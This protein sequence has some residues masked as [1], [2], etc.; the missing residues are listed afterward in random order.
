MKPKH[1]LKPTFG[2]RVMKLV[3]LLLGLLLGGMVAVTAY[4]Q[5]QI[6]Q[7][8]IQPQE[9]LPTLQKYVAE[10]LSYGETERNGDLIGGKGSGIVN[11]LLIGQD[12]EEG[13]ERA[14]SDS[15]ILCSFN[16]KSKKLTMTSFLRDLYVKIPG[17]GSNRI[18]AAYTFG[19]MEL[20]DRTIRENFGVYIDAN[21][22]VDFTQFAQIVNTLGGVEMELRA[23][24]AAHI[25]QKTGIETQEGKQLLNGEQALTYARIR[26]LDADGDFARTNRQ[27]KVMTAVIGTYKDAGLGTVLDTVDALFP[28]VNT[29]MNP[30]EVVKYA[31]DLFPVLSDGELVSQRIP[32]DGAY[33]DQRIDGMSV[34]VAD[35][36][37][38][39]ELLRTTLVGE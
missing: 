20:L 37:A 31:V 28:M 19:G 11:I 1:K 5:H 12:R 29:D 26:K 10:N 27:R 25:T 16:K 2:R 23:D 32:A 36:D 7:G 22:E 30:L 18:N 21:V 6:N 15:M 4:F 39:R 13:E 24:E 35:M 3:C 14:R 9:A 38:A 8:R 33:E 34:L 17:F